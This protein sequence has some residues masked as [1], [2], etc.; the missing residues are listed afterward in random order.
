MPPEINPEQLVII[1]PCVTQSINHVH[2]LCLSNAVSPGLCLQVILGVPVRVKDHHSIGSG[3]VHTET[4]GP[5]RQEEAEIL[6]TF[7]VEVVDGILTQVT[8]D[9]T[10]EPLV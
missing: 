7:G 8:A 5:G 9:R 2:L 6:R 4:A 3:Q 1:V 10:I